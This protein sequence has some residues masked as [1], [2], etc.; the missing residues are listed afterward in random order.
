MANLYSQGFSYEKIGCMFGI[1]RQAVFESLK[2]F[3]VVS[4]TKKILPFIMY[5]NIKW[6][7][8]NQGYYRNTNRGARGNLLL[9]RYKYQKER[10]VIPDDWDVHHID[11]DKTN[12]NI[13]NLLALPKDEHTKLHQNIKKEKNEN[14]NV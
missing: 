5:D 9:H 4:R 3:G 14:N 8:F 10:G 6:T 11:F 1:T 2:N 7:L 12:N 13:S